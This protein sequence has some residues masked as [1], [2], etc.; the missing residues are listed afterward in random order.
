MEQHQLTHPRAGELF[1]RFCQK[2]FPR[3]ADGTPDQAA[4]P[5]F[6]AETC[7]VPPRECV[8]SENTQK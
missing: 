6:Y 4:I 5:A 8:T 2:P 1:C 3:L 7:P